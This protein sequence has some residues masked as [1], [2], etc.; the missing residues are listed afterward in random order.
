M[1][2]TIGFSNPENEQQLRCN[3]LGRYFMPWA[4][5]VSMRI[6]KEQLEEK[7]A[8][9]DLAVGRA[10]LLAEESPSYAVLKWASRQRNLRPQLYTLFNESNPEKE[11]QWRAAVNSLP[12]LDQFTFTPQVCCA[13]VDQDIRKAVASVRSL[14][15]LLS[16][17]LCQ[18]QGLTW[19]WLQELVQVHRAD[20]FLW[21]DFECL[22]SWNKRKRDREQLHRI[23]GQTGTA[24]LQQG[25]KKRR[26]AADKEAYWKAMLEQ[27]LIQVLGADHLGLLCFSFY[28]KADKA[29]Q[30]L[31]FLTLNPEAYVNMRAIMS[32]ESQTIEDGIGDCA[33][34][35]NKGAQRRVASPTLFG[36]MFELEQH[37]L[38]TYRNQTMQVVDLYEEQHWGR[39]LTK[40]NYIDALL[41]LEKKGLIKIT[42]KRAPRGR[43]LPKDHL[44]DKTFLSFKPQRS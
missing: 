30:S 27:R 3:L 13:P 34:Y 38:R 24:V 2:A 17:D 42:R 4:K 12:R 20:C 33:Y 1:A 25:L 36:P 10:D 11:E 39:A 40:K 21:V 23:F 9:I 7:F 28:D 37:L 43:S 35:P 16:A 5:Q 18:N 8:Y 29:T 22:Q 32:N 6:F 41:N 44:P 14:P 31:Y 26:K 19:E 15:T